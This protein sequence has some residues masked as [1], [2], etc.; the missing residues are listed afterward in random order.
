MLN[1]RPFQARTLEQGPVEA[2]GA[3]SGERK[4]GSVR[5]PGVVAPAAAATKPARRAYSIR[6]CPPGWPIE[7]AQAMWA[8]Y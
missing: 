4:G 6:F 5:T 2:V 1:F 3:R 7:S 8:G